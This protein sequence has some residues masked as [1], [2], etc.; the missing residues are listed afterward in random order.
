VVRDLVHRRH[1]VPLTGCEAHGNRHLRYG[2]GGCGA[3]VAI[4]AWRA[5]N[6]GETGG[7]QHT[8]PSGPRRHRFFTTLPSGFGVRAYAGCIS[9]RRG[10]GTG[11]GLCAATVDLEAASVKC[12]SLRFE[13]IPM[14]GSCVE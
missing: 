14:L 13:A 3:G 2:I 5:G 11:V 4:T 6:Q 1:R 7:R 12:T 10:P 8:A 9:T